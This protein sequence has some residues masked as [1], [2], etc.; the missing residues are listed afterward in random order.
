MHVVVVV[1]GSGT[2]RVGVLEETVVAIIGS[3]AGKK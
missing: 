1:S 2:T 3:G